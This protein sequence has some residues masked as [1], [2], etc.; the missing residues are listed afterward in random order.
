MKEKYYSIR[1]LVEQH[2]DAHYYVVYGERSNGKTYSTLD[3]CIEDYFKKGYQFAYVRRWKEDI[4]ISNLQKLFDG[5]LRDHKIEKYSKG[6]W[7]GI[8][9]KSRMFY[10]TRYETKVDDKGKKQQVKIIDDKPFCYVYVLTDDEHDKGFESPMIYNILF[11]EFIARGSYIPDEFTRFMNVISTIKRRRT[12]IRVFMLGN[13]INRFSI[14]FNEMG[15]TNIK[16]QKIGTIDVYKYGDSGL[17]VVCEFA[18]MKN[19]NKET[20][21]YFAFKNPKLQMITNG[22]WELAIYPHITPEMKY[23]PKHVK[24]KYFIEFDGSI[25]E[26]DIVLLPKEKTEEVDRKQSMLFTFVHAK[27]TDIREDNKNLVYSLTP[28]PKPNYR[29]NIMKPY[30]RIEKVI[31]DMFYKDKVFYQSNDIGDIVHNYM[32]MCT[33]IKKY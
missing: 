18:E 5:I 21:V 17:K 26:C 25:L 1:H 4:K 29:R 15:L 31:I 8:L 7:T 23:K 22:T 20:D 13:T 19:K 14:Y 33:S 11:D 30:S 3:L 28:N 24:Y 12:G 16:T 2:P 9:Y 27:T 32:N 10:F 6:K